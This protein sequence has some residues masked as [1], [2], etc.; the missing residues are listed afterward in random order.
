M[1]LEL[2]R[3]SGQSFTTRQRLLPLYSL[4]LGFVCS[5]CGQYGR[6]RPISSLSKFAKI[7]QKHSTSRPSF[8]GA[9]TVAGASAPA[10]LNKLVSARPG[11]NED[12]G[13]YRLA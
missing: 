5:Q 2:G 4:Y 11:L 10:M 12:N 13:L 8:G 3:F 9:R 6:D 7:A 1:F